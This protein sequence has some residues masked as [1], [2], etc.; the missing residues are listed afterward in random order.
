MMH[1]MQTAALA[2]QAGSS[3]SL[4]L[5][6]LL[7]DIGHF[8]IDLSGTPSERGIN[9]QHEYRA[10]H[11]L[12]S[13]LPKSVTEPIR[14]HVKAKRCLVCDPQYFAQLSEDSKRSLQLQGGTMNSAERAV[15]EQEEFHQAALELRRFDDLAKDPSFETQSWESYWALAEKLRIA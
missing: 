7:H 2:L 15:F 5:A 14:L 13:C 12:K 1:A 6:S 9:D 10:A 11:A 3:N 8:L 4:I